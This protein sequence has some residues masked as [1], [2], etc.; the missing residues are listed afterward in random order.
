MLMAM[1]MVMPMNRVC[2]IEID[3]KT[4]PRR[5]TSFIVTTIIAIMI[6]IT[7]CSVVYK[8]EPE[9][10]QLLTD[11]EINSQMRPDNRHT[12]STHSTQH[13]VRYVRDYLHRMSVGV[14]VSVSVC[15]LCTHTQCD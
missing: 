3:E 9:G 15:I 8:C 4:A 10:K 11:P 1:S 12:T 14:R 6:T 7:V 13:P 2:W 5:A